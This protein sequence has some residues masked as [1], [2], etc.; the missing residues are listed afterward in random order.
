MAVVNGVDY[1]TLDSVAAPAPGAFSSGAVSF[2]AGGAGASASIDVT[3]PVV[4]LWILL[5][6]E[7]FVLAMLHRSLRRHNGG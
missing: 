6:V 1:G 2:G 5:G 7:L 3:T 4:S